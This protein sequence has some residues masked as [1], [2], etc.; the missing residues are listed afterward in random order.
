MTRAECVYFLYK[1]KN[2]TTA[3]TPESLAR[4]SKITIEDGDATYKLRNMAATEAKIIPDF[5]IDLF[6]SGNFTLIFSNS[7]SKYSNKKYDDNV[8]LIGE[9]ILNSAGRQVVLFPTDEY[10]A[11]YH[12]LGH[13]ATIT[14]KLDETTFLNN[15]WKYDVAGAKE[16]T[17]WYSQTNP[18]ECW[19]EA[20]RYLMTNQNN[21]EKMA[22]AKKK[23]PVSYAFFKTL[24]EY[25]QEYEKNK[26]S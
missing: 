5:F 17:G 7:I 21:S 1:L 22:L 13:V 2:C 6:N 12:E 23:I 16:L 25:G 24:V 8:T 14:L 15:V 11:L 19:A 18:D 3:P 26:A 10:T 9:T 4:F 20:F